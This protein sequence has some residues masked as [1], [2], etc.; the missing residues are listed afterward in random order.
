MRNILSL[1]KLL[2]LKY[3]DDS[4]PLLTLGNQCTHH[5][6]MVRKPQVTKEHESNDE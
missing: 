6:E 5:K 2:L 1:V 4:R 3:T